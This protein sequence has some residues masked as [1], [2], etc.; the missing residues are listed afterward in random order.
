MKKILRGTSKHLLS[1]RLIMVFFLIA[2]FFALPLSGFSQ[3]TDSIFTPEEREWLKAHP[4]ITIGVDPDFLPL[5]AI[6][7]KGN[8]IGIA[9]EYVAQLEKIMGVQM[10][11]AKN[12]TWSQVLEG[13]KVGTVDVVDC[14]GK[15]EE[16][17]KYLIF[18]EPYI[19]FPAVIITR[20]TNREITDMDTLKNKS[21]TVVEKYWIHDILRFVHPDLM[22]KTFPTGRQC[23]ESVAV[24]ETD[25]FVSDLASASYLIKQLG[26]SNLRISGYSP[27]DMPLHMGVRK[28]LPELV[29]I[30]NKAIAAIP[31]ADKNVIFDRWITIEER[32]IYETPLFW[33]VT[34]AL[35]AV[36]LLVFFIIGTWNRTL[37]RQVMWKTKQLNQELAERKI[38]E[39]KFHKVFQHAADA[40]GLVRLSDGKFLEVNNAFFK[41][42]GY[43]PEDVIGHTTSEFGLYADPGNRDEIYRQLFSGQR[44]ESFEVD[45][46]TQKNEIRSG[47]LSTELIDIEGDRCIT[48]VWHD[49]TE[50]KYS[51]IALLNAFDSLDQK[52][53]ERTAELG[54]EKERAESASRAKSIF[55][56]NVSHELRTPLN[57]ILGYSNLMLREENLDA[58]QL[59]DLMVIH[60]SGEHLLNLINEVLEIS[61]IEAGKTILSLST[62]NLRS[63]LNDLQ[64]MFQMRAEEKSIKLTFIYHESLPENL[65]SD[66]NKVR[67]ILINLIGNSVK[68][69]DSGTIEVSVNV[70]SEADKSMRL[71][72]DV[73]DTGPGIAENDILIVFMPFHQ[74]DSGVRA[75]SGS[76]LGLAISRDFARLMGGDIVAVS[77]IGKGSCFKLEIPVQESFNCQPKIHIDYR[78]VMGPVPSQTSYKVLVADDIAENRALLVRLLEI[79]GMNVKEAADGQ[80]ALNLW[81]DWHPD[82]ILIDLRMPVVDGYE[83]MR[84]IRDN[85]TEPKTKIIV[86][87]AS[88]FD[89]D[90][91]RVIET[92]G[93][94][95][96][97]RKPVIE[98]ELFAVLSECLGIEYTYEPVQEDH[99]IPTVVASEFN[100]NDFPEPLRIKL[101]SAASQADIE[102]I[103]SL[104]QVIEVQFP[105]HVKVIRSLIEEFRYDLLIKALDKRR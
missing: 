30:L 85:D 19:R 67:Q 36:A 97:I 104:L 99:G 39:D 31:E 32:S 87:T 6:D 93:A 83:A 44:L 96:F 3:T 40:I 86:V 91:K 4:V 103:T 14:L 48:F 16:R 92:T 72:V 60:H 66:E 28:E 70:T 50:R 15:T 7:A 20:N 57:A 18:T 26:L 23:L 74:S 29:P 82:L 54:I 73:S 63:M 64:T 27:Y 56:A 89:G 76:G 98:S 46:N 53:Q 62:F 35:L 12:L 90:K 34:G 81:R 43:D 49:I 105:N 75:G 69:T 24:G 77:T 9:A 33:Y 42:L 1:F 80:E 65:I 95:G 17:Q 88:A 79:V 47:L 94:L 13:A 78:R 102:Q 41:I 21:V 71:H 2:V 11:P 100:S 51:E 68:F 25:A 8:F 58:N 5:E 10:I 38:A 45:W 101:L 61:R 52:V 59:K 22:L 55:L 84:F 37:K